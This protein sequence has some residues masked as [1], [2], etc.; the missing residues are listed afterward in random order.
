[1]NPKVDQIDFPQ[2][3]KKNIQNLAV[4]EREVFHV[5]INEG[6]LIP[7]HPEYWD[8]SLDGTVPHLFK[9]RI[10]LDVDIEIDIRNLKIP[11][12]KLLPSCAILRKRKG[13]G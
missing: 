3:A 11:T 2:L 5:D 9:I 13:H 12:R 4:V 7:K 1:M 10:K 8:I 6:K